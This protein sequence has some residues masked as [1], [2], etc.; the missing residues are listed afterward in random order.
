MNAELAVQ[1][2]SVLLLGRV[3]ERVRIPSLR[4]WAALPCCWAA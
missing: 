1:P 4:F 2:A 3:L